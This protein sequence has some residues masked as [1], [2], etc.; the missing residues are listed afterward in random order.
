V[1]RH[2]DPAAHR[3]E[4]PLDPFERRVER[5]G[6]DRHVGDRGR[7]RERA[8]RRAGIVVALRSAGVAGARLPAPWHGLCGLWAIER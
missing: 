6:E 4:A 5:L 1:R 3:L 8:F 7:G 2:G